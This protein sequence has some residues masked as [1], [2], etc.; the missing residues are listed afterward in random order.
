MKF[1]ELKKSIKESCN[2]HSNYVLNQD[3]ITDIFNTLVLYGDDYWIKSISNDDHN[4][5][6][7]GFSE[8]NYDYYWLCV[9]EKCNLHFV[10]N[11]Y[12]IENYH[13]IDSKIFSDEEKNKI[14]KNIIRYFEDNKNERLLFCK[15]ELETLNM[16]KKFNNYYAIQDHKKGRKKIN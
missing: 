1:N 7:I 12:V 5:C 14:I 9:D 16:F 8:T 2:K 10:T 15:Y 4:I 11:L 6:I 3:I 13:T